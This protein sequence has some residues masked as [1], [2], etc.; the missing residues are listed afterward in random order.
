VRAM[1]GPEAETRLRQGGLIAQPM[2]VGELNVYIAAET[3]RWKPVL[4]RVGLAG[5]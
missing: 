5:K 3:A 1:T 2:T 4:E